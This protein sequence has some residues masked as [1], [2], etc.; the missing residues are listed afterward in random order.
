MADDR[1]AQTN[2]AVAQDRPTVHL[3][4]IGFQVALRRRKCDKQDRKSGGSAR[5]LPLARIRTRQRGLHLQTKSQLKKNTAFRL[6]ALAY[7]IGRLI[8][9]RTRLFGAST[10][11]AAALVAAARDPGSVFAVVSRG[12]RPDLAADSLKLVR[13]PTLLIVGG[14]DPV[15]LDLNKS[16]LR[17][18]P[19][20]SAL[21][22]VP[23]AT[24]LFE[25][26]GKLE[27]VSPLACRWFTDHLPDPASQRPRS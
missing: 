24:H 6:R 23:G 13:A 27:A 26:P 25:E 14:E 19:R 4:P 5:R 15:V 11:A 20:G 10:G 3:D 2:R 17:Q 22:V 9:E 18:L 8:A 21:E 16:A 7:P 1:C 12:G